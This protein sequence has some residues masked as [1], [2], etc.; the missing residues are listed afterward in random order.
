MKKLKRIFLVLLILTAI[1]FLFRGWLYRHLITYKSVGERTTYLAT[2]K[3]L[4]EYIDE[5][6]SSNDELDAEDIIKKSLSIT[7]KQ[8]N[9][10]TDKN[11]NDPNKLIKTKTAHCVGYASF[12]STICNYLFKK[13]NL[14]DTWSAKPQIGQLYLFNNNIHKYFSSPFFKDHDFVI[15]E[16]KETK[17]IFSV[18]PTINDYLFINFITIG[19]NNQ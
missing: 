18:D 9:F 10:A 14:D 7:S 2:D 3:N 12:Y 13:Y 19:N 8:L 16:N 1:V 5:S 11:S 6:I 4:I 17:E 15:I